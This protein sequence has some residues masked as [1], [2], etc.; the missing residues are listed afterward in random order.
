M[1]LAE[2]I[3]NHFEYGITK[4]ELIP[5]SGGVFIIDVNGQNI[6]TKDTRDFPV[7]EEIIK[8]MENM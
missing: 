3:F 6:F 2:D 8:L 7:P 1:S 4:M 5:G